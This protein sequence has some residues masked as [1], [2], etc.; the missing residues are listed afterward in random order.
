[1]F[2]INRQN[3]C[4]R[5]R[6][7]LPQFWG[8]FLSFLL[9]ILFASCN[10]PGRNP[11]P[12]G[13]NGENL[14]AGTPGLTGVPPFTH[15]P[16]PTPTDPPRTLTI[17]LASEPESLFLYGSPSLAQRR[18]LAA[19]Y[20]GPLDIVEYT[21]QPVI[22]E[23][24][25]SLAD[26]DA[27]LKPV[28]VERGDWVVN[29][30]GQL[31]PLDT[32]QLVRP[33]GCLSSECAIVW[34]GAALE[35][36]Q[37]TATFTLKAGVTW[38]DGM[39]LTAADS[40]FSYE[41]ARQCQTE[42]GFCG[43]LGLISQSNTTLQRTA[44]YTVLDE[45]TVQWAGIPGF[46]DP[47]YPANFFFP[48]PQ[49]QLAKRSF[50]ELLTAEESSRRPLGWGA[51]VIER[52]V[53]GDHILLRANPTY[54][55][56]S[57]GLPRFDRLLLRFFGVEATNLSDGGVERLRN[58]LSTGLCDLFDEEL[59]ATF[60]QGGVAQLRSQAESGELS[61]SFAAG[62][63]WEQLTFGIR[64]VSY[65]DGFQPGVDRPDLL[66]DPRTRQGLALCTARERLLEALF[67]GLSSIPKSY[68]PPEHPLANPDLPRYEHD[69]QA[70]AALLEQVGWLERDGDMRTPRTAAG[71]PGI[72][73]D[74]P[75]QLTYVVSDAAWRREA[76]EILSASL[77][78]C[79]VAIQ[80]EV[81]P[82]GE[83]YAPG[84][85]GPV[86]GR[87]FDL[88]QFAWSA[89]PQ[90]RCDLWTTAQIPGDPS[91]TNAEGAPLFPYGWGGTNAGGFSNAEF[92][93]ACRAAS[94]ALPGQEGYLPAHHS[95][96][97]IFASQLPVLPL[98]QRLRV[99]VARSDL[100][101]FTFDPSAR[102]ELTGIELFDYGQG[103]KQ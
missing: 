37:L 87:R 56:A 33:A 98:Y 89:A 70:G 61:A 74:T 32:G 26:G 75:L 47:N 23:K 79:G 99:V 101:G 13:V 86:F 5:P 21:Y 49:H 57:E 80:L 10:F 2:E 50:D 42:S 27:F 35:M 12:R 41:I 52:W 96:Q 45:H 48:L 43:G 15:T 24:L 20:D 17:C 85:E 36:D 7:M 68:L 73:D 55:R 51:Y 71:I 6:L 40:V 30:S 53:P 46:R 81:S 76:A 97:E 39:P 8:V 1:M 25:P 78:E 82:A 22:L 95:A 92:D 14:P 67:D 9:L 3:G 29:D 100:C 90:P 58:A 84:P 94:E 93:Q 91:L 64:P 63:E 38:S 65:D 62:P 16:D 69:P 59:S 4:L 31:V 103:C 83:V 44:S 66:G 18:V 60:L 102:S 72:P 77:A 88:A 19:I 11:E 28:V 54:F 34:D